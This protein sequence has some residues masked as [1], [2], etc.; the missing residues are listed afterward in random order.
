MPAPRPP[1]TVLIIGGGLFGSTTA[2][3]LAKGPYKGHESLITVVERGQDLALDAASS[4]YNK[5][6][7]KLSLLS[8][9][10]TSYRPFTLVDATTQSFGGLDCSI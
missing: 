7:R 1:Q 4:D 9:P 6:S 5:V 2:L 3:S 8:S 10:L